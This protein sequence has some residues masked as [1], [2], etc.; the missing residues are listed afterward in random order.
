[1]AE[2]AEEFLRRNRELNEIKDR[3]GLLDGEV[4]GVQRAIVELKAYTISQGIQLKFMMEFY[5]EYMSGGRKNI[6]MA[7][8][9]NEIVIELNVALASLRGKLAEEAIPEDAYKYWKKDARKR[10]SRIVGAE[11][12]N[13]LIASV[14]W[15]KIIGFPDL[16]VE[17]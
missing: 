6:N 5:R 7:E 2:D 16:E 17:E 12:A 9:H 4:T 14:D 1:M 10:L 8:K 11:E 3:I 13:S 15:E